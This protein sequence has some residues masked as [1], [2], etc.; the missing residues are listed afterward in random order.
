MPKA[1]GPGQH[2]HSAGDI[3]DPELL[4]KVMSWLFL[5]F[6][7]FGCPGSSLRYLQGLFLVAL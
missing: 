4:V 3:V 7:Y 5:K 6:I 1:L 2:L